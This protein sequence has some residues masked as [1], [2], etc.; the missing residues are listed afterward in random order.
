MSCELPLAAGTLFQ[1]YLG[2]WAACFQGQCWWR[3]SGSWKRSRGW[4]CRHHCPTAA[5]AA[6]AD[7]CSPGCSAPAAPSELVSLPPGNSSHC[8]KGLGDRYPG[9]KLQ[10]ERQ[11]GSGS[12]ELRMSEH[13]SEHCSVRVLSTKDSITISGSQELHRP[14]YYRDVSTSVWGWGTLRWHA[15]SLKFP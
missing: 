6:V 13:L 9:Q 15:S 8:S 11:A 7:N 2:R 1:S 5:P 14:T 10:G 4:L 12:T 3:S